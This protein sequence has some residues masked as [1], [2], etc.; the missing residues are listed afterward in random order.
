MLMGQT[1]ENACPWDDLSPLLGSGGWAA[2]GSRMNQSL[3]G[4]ASLTSCTS[5]GY[6]RP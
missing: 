5:W 2:C 6:R 1:I 3:Y 4:Q